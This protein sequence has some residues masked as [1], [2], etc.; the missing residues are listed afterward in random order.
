MTG[1]GYPLPVFLVEKAGSEK[2]RKKE[3]TKGEHFA[4]V[5]ELSSSG[6]A[7]EAARKKF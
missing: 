3:L 6:R 7:V 2:G 1:R 5:S 4:I